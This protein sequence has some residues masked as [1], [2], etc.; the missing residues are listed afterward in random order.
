MRQPAQENIIQNMLICCCAKLGTGPRWGNLVTPM[1]RTPAPR[2]ILDR[3]SPRRTYGYAVINPRIRVC[4]PSSKVL[5]PTLHIRSAILGF[6]SIDG[7]EIV[8]PKEL[9]HDHKSGR[10]FLS[11]HAK[12]ANFRIFAAN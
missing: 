3:G 1:W 12:Q 6:V 2:P 10:L 8:M 7:K 9:D 11:G 5:S 4:Q